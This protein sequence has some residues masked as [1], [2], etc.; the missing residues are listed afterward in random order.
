M[1]I[2]EIQKS[3]LNAL[4]SLYEQLIDKRTNYDKLFENYEA[5]I[6]N[7]QY[8][9][10]GAKADGKLLGSLMGI[11]CFDLVGECYPFM[12]VENVIVSE[13]HRGMGI[14]RKLFESIEQIAIEN[15]CSY[16]FFVSSDY[17]D[18]AHKFYE[19]IGYTK[20]KVRG[21]KKFLKA[22]AF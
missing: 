9:L 8:F 5:L 21:F 13:G 18:G 4:G 16:I 7:G 22:D 17:R 12:V 19:S 11:K 6:D 20:D 2:V 1:E 3:D 10:L 15:N 14:G